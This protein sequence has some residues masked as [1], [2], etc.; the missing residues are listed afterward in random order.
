MATLEKIRTRAGLLITIVI[1]IAL[2]SFLVNPQDVVNYFQSSK[3]NVGVINGKKIDYQRFAGEID[4]YQQ[5]TDQTAQSEEM[6]ERV[7]QQAWE[8]LLREYMFDSEYEKIGLSI[9]EKELTDLAVGT[10]LSPIIMSIPDFTN[11][12]TGEVNREVLEMFWRNPNN[13]PQVQALIGYLEAEIKDYA[14]M[15]KYGSLIS[16]A[17]YVNSLEL[18]RAIDNSAN[19]VEFNYVVERFMA[20]NAADSLYP[21][22]DSEA[23]SYYNK[24]KK[25]YEQE[26][27]RDIEFVAFQVLPSGED[28]IETKDGLEKLAPEFSVA[29][30]LARFVR[31]NSE[32]G[33]FDT[34]YYRHGELSSALDSFAFAANTS[35]VLMP[36]LEG[37]TYKMA[38]VNDRRMMADSVYFRNIIVGGESME[39]A[40]KLADS[41]VN[42][43]KNGGDWAALAAQYSMDQQTARNGGELGWRMQEELPYPLNDSVFTQPTG[44][45]MVFPS[46]NGIFIFQ[47]TQKTKEIPKVQL[48]VVQKEVTPS[49][50]THEEARGKA[51]DLSAKSQGG[52]E[53]FVQ[54]VEEGGYIKQPAANIYRSSKQVNAITNAKSLVQWVYGDKIKK[55]SISDVIDV[56]LKYYIVA[57]VTE[58]R[59]EGVAPFEQMKGQITDILAKE[60]QGE[61]LANKV[62]EAMAGA[63]TLEDIA[64]KLNTS[65][66]QVTNPVTFGAPNSYASYVPGMGLE[67]KVVAT[68][69]SL[70]ES[71]KLS[72]PVI[73]NSGVY[74]ISVTERRRDEGY[75][76][77]LAKLGLEQMAVQQQGLMMD[78]LLKAYNVKDYRARFF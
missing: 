40:Q 78:V 11:P 17:N 23:K 7:R 76:S 66:L 54:A 6:S 64:T 26:E 74:V 60:K 14:L 35:E 8:K 75:S 10:N 71:A 55:G 29:T 39:S 57:A 32:G 68:A 61:A 9:S 48:A 30:D 41:L 50:K 31:L 28:F 72:E 77:Q 58:V 25:N 44:K 5:F 45:I 18:K 1:G 69:T 20:G 36:V 46:S 21:V 59:E 38:R 73:G 43:L 52:Y 2:L 24:H 16:K 47:A 12:Q 70:P 27:S 19:S 49:R 67:P 4:Y 33:N 15:M 3:N 34:R 37:F 56:D 51:N 42:L 22:S 63:N 65:V 13:N 53:A 62:K